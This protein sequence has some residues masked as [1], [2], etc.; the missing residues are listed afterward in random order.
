MAFRFWFWMLVNANI[1]LEWATKRDTWSLDLKCG[2]INSWITSEPFNNIF[3]CVWIMTM[4]TK[5]IDITYACGMPIMLWRICHI[6]V[7]HSYSVSLAILWKQICE[8]FF[9]SLLLVK[10]SIWTDDDLKIVLIFIVCVCVRLLKY[11]WFRSQDELLENIL[12]KR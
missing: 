6:L 7:A 9:C 5:L 4:N 12:L 10:L 1:N 2:Q 11:V 8:S 3:S